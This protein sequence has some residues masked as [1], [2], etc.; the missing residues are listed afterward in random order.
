MTM[1]S[2]HSTPILIPPSG[3]ATPLQRVPLSGPES[4]A[5]YSEAWLQHLLY[6]FPS[7]LPISE[8]DDSF[9]GAIP[10][11]REMN[12]PAGPVDVVYVTPNGRPVI[13][14]AKLWR[15]PEARRK[16]VGQVLDYAKELGRFSYESFDAAVRAARRAMD[17]EDPPQGVAD[18]V[19]QAST[20]FVE[21]QFHDSLTRNLR[22]GEFLLLIV[23]DGIREGVGA[24]ADFLE[25]HGGLHF[26]FGLVEM[27]VYRTPDNGQLVQPRVLVQST[28]IR[29]TVVELVD[30]TMSVRDE[31]GE[32]G[33]E[34]AVEGE[35]QDLLQRRALYSAFWTKF[36]AA[37]NVDDKSQPIKRPSLGTNQGFPLPDGVEGGMSAYLARS[38]GSAGVYLA[39]R[40]NPVGKR[41]YAALLEDREAIEQAL[42]FPIEW[43]GNEVIIAKRR[44]DGELADTS[45][46]DIVQWLVPRVNRMITVFRPRLQTLVKDAG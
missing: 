32:V 29:R 2:A 17:G 4:T 34:S 8:I 28:I 25:A 16:V 26:T 39:F 1:S 38:S 27:A 7:A 21:A 12:T 37:L 3:I 36:L 33:E 31:A 35:R 42:G 15:N 45:R 18:L 13:V 5:V 40:D 24:I 23:G 6:R 30:G 20:D 41:Q 44:F 11:C 43:E 9:S 46:N 19:R 10:V 14:E 22:R